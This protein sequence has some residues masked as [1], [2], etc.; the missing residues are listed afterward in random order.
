[1]VASFDTDTNQSSG[2]ET[3]PPPNGPGTEN[4]PLAHAVTRRLL[5]APDITTLALSAFTGSHEHCDDPA[6]EVYVR[7]G[8]G[9]H[10]VAPLAPWKTPY[11]P[12][13]HE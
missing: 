9:T 1:M 4:V 10:A 2:C 3:Q 6:E 11:V 13:G 12:R 7:S 5:R 8:Q